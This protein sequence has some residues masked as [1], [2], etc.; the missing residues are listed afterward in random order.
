LSKKLPIREDLIIR[1][2]LIVPEGTVLVGRMEGAFGEVKLEPS[3]LA[4]LIGLF[5]GF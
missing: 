5:I 1:D 4:D 2:E 3:C